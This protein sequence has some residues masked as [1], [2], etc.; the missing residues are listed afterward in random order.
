MRK[1][2]VLSGLALIVCFG[3]NHAIAQEA[4]NQT[5]VAKSADGPGHYYH[6]EFVVQ[7]MGTDG[8]PVNS[9][10]YAVDT[11]SEQSNRGVSIRTGSRVPVASSQNSF[12]YVDLGVNIDVHS[13]REVDGK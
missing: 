13:S 6:L 2:I 4:S 5:P 11:K 12:Q 1:L 7:E 3:A 10:A 8:K 9:R